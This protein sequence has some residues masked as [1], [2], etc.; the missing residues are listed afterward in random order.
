M[1]GGAAAVLTGLV[2]VAVSIHLRPVLRQPWH[3]GRAGSSLIALLSVVLVAGAVLLP[4]QPAAA[5][6]IEVIGIALL[7]PAYNARGLAHLPADRRG[8]SLLE[9]AAGLVGAG[10]AILAG[11][12]L[13]AGQGGGLW[14]L[15]PAGIVALCTSTWNAWRLMVDVA[16]EDEADLLQADER[17]DVHARVVRGADNDD[18]DRVRPARGPG[19]DVD[20]ASSAVARRVELDLGLVHAVEVDPGGAAPGSQVRG[21]G[22]R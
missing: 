6:G 12:S 19:V 4:G 18:R 15:V 8:R 7:S 3:R 22:N 11:V 21:P 16:A 14:L 2:F 9:V 13:I 10:L 17:V 5:L 20:D 1:V